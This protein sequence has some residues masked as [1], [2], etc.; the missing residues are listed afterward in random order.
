LA[1]EEKQWQAEKAALRNDLKMAQP[2]FLKAVGLLEDCQLKDTAMS[3]LAAI[4]GEFEDEEQ[5][6]QW[7]LKRIEIPCATNTTKAESYYALGV[8]QWSCAYTLTS[9][10]SNPKQSATDPF[11][12]RAIANPADK[13]KFASCLSDGAAYL[14]KAL[15]ANPNYTDAL[16]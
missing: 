1:E 14:E 2:A 5:S 3:Y 8:K 16:F 15:Q 7:L 6:K 9:K 12:F 10:Y 4:A 11:H 13:Q